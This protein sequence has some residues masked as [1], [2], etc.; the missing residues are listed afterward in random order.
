M[1]SDRRDTETAG[2][3]WTPHPPPGNNVGRF[4][5]FFVLKYFM[6]CVCVCVSAPADANKS[7]ERR[8]TLGRQ[9]QSSYDSSD[10]V[11][12]PEHG[13]LRRAANHSPCL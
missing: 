9:R 8:Q 12:R 5:L 6:V 2:Q 4:V 3:Q 13:S 1:E 7:K 11:L 10:T